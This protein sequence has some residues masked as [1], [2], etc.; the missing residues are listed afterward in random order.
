M[1][2]PSAGVAVRSD[3]ARVIVVGG[4]LFGSAAARH[5]AEAG[6]STLVVT[7]PEHPGE[8]QVPG[9]RAS[10][11]D[12]GRIVRRG[13]SDPVMVEARGRTMD[14][15]PDVAARSGV[16]FFTHRTLVTLTPDAERELALSLSH[17]ADVERCPTE[18]VTERFGIASPAGFEGDAIVEA[19]TTAG[20]VNPRLLVQAQLRLAEMAGA[21]IVDSPARAITIGGGG[22]QPVRVETADGR[23]I[24]GDQLLMA[25]GPYGT[26]LIDSTL[27]DIDIDIDINVDIPIQRRLRTIALI[28]VEDGDTTGRDPLP[29][30]SA[31][32][33][34]HPDGDTPLVEETYWVPPVRYPDGGTYLKI[35]GNSLPMITADDAAASDDIDRWFAGGGSAVEADALFAL[36]TDLLPGHSLRLAGHKPC[37][38]SYT[39]EEH[40]VVRRIDERIAV[41]LAGNGSGASVSDEIGRRAATLIAPGR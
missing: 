38:V 34:G 24:D 8:G 28:D 5:L 9:P 7:S 2:G 40:P 33:F 35:G 27:V 37:V 4:G 10:H 11:Y 29:S 3:D 21:T 17:G 32:G 1:L 41:V 12:Q 15:L 30:L 20:F 14:R 39:A 23:H 16:D 19:A 36:A 18:T 26:A 13:G 22:R 25:T 6:V 31:S